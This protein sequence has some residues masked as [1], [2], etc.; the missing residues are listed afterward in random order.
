LH[1]RGFDE[2]DANNGRKIKKMKHQSLYDSIMQLIKTNQQPFGF[3]L[4]L[5]GIYYLKIGLNTEVKKDE[6]TTLIS[7]CR[8]ISGAIAL[9]L[10]A[11]ILLMNKL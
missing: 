5:L 10:L 1:E 6:Y 11:L 3:I 9:I 2:T 4:L 7:K 8:S